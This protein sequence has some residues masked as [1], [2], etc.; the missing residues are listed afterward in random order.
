MSR[1]LARSLVS[2]ALLAL[3]ASSGFACHGSTT[4]PKAANPH[5][6]DPLNPREVLSESGS[7]I[8]LSNDPH[9]AASPQPAP[10]GSNIGGTNPPSSSPPPAA[11]PDAYKPSDQVPAPPK[12]IGGGPK[13]ETGGAVYG[14]GNQGNTGAI[15]GGDSPP[16]NDPKSK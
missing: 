6:V 7:T 4:E 8:E 16:P 11:P 10:Q 3:A 12:G 2:A 15:K 1:S 5:T 9:A 14:D 13:N